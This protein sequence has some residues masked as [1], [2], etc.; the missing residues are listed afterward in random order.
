MPY[1]ILEH[2]ADTGLRITGPSLKE[3]F[4]SAARGRNIEEE[5]AKKGI[6]VMGRGCK[7]M[8]EE[9]P[10]AYKDVNDVVNVMRGAGIARK[11]VRLPAG[12]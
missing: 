4:L 7:G 10:D 2:T 3:I 12:K 6:V 1:S 8:V 11:I 5:L 9:Q